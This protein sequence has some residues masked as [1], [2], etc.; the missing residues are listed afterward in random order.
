M[1]RPQPQLLQTQKLV[2]VNH[3]QKDYS[4]AL[5]CSA[6][7]LRQRENDRAVSCHS[8]FPFCFIS[9]SI[10]ISQYFALFQIHILLFTDPFAGKDDQH[11]YDTDFHIFVLVICY[12]GI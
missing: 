9:V 11:N 1:G 7:P 2:L 6:H 5:W 4:R 3:A 8:S 10:K 12:I